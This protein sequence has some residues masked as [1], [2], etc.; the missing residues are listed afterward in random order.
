MLTR[1]HS[2][3]GFFLSSFL[4]VQWKWVRE[5]ESENRVYCCIGVYYTSPTHPVTLLHPC[6]CRNLTILF[7]SLHPLFLFLIGWTQ[8][9]FLNVRHKRMNALRENWNHDNL[10]DHICT[11]VWCRGQYDTV[12]FFMKPVSCFV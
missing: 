11:W 4:K 6:L 8:W 3:S 12:I 10:I 9:H 5:S 1:T 2:Y 7:L